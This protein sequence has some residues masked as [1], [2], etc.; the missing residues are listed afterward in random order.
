MIPE[1][2]GHGKAV[3]GRRVSRSFASAGNY[4]ATLTVSDGHGG[5]DT[6]SVAISVAAPAAAFPQ[7]AVLDN[8]NRANGVIGGNWVDQTASYSIV[9]NALVPKLGDVYVEWNGATFGADQ[10]AYVTLNTIS[11]S[12]PEHNLMLKTQGTT[13]RAGHIEVSYNAAASKVI[14]Y[15]FTPPSMWQTIGTI[16]NVTFAAG[17][18][19]GARARNDGTVQVYRNGVLLDSVSVAGWAYAALGGRIGLSCSNATASRFDDFGG[20]TVPATLPVS[21]P[22]A[23]GSAGIPRSGRVMLSGA[24]PN[25]TNGGVTLSVELPQGKDVSLGVLDIQGREVWSAPMR[26]YGS[27][28]WSLRWDGRTAHGPASTGLYLVSVR[29]GA[30]SYLRRIAVIH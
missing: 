18:Q 6:A 16:G 23:A 30:L 9:S 17:S 10:E 25:P 3:S 20:G 28:R 1:S 2:D 4:A 19:F 12:A 29:V 21:V 8:F 26:H 7:T 27:G 22:A 13:W 15:T 11:T 14:V 24:F 5:I